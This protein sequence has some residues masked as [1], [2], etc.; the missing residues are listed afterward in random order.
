MTSFIEYKEGDKLK[1]RYSLTIIFTIVIVAIVI[2]MLY[3]GW[4][5][6]STT[7]Y[8]FPSPEDV[9]PVA[10]STPVDSTVT[11]SLDGFAQCLATSGLKFY[12]ASWCIHCKNQKALFGSAV[13]YLPYVECAD[14]ASGI[15]ACQLA[16]INSYPTWV[17]SA[18]VRYEGEQ[19]LEK[20]AEISGCVLPS[21]N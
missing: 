19:S 2:G 15:R 20:L 6:V 14:T 17:T 9:V 1:N 18:G 7:S 11:S 8:P 16:R 10:T 21:T 5:K 13:Q 12:G 4:S 3:I